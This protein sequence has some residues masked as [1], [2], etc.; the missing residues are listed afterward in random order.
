MPVL[1]DSKQ[2]FEGVTLSQ[3]QF[4]QKLRDG[5]VNVS[6]SQPNPFDVEELWT[7]IL[8]THDALVHIP[9]SSGL[10]ETCS[11]LSHLAH[12]KFDKRVFVADNQRI[13]VT[14]KQSV[15]DAV[16][17]AAEGKS[18]EEIC[19]RL[20]ET[21]AQSSIYIM[22][23]TLK[24][25]KKG[26]RLTPAA[27][28]IGTLLRIK[29]ILQIQGQKLD[30]YAKVRR[31]SDA[32]KTMLKAIGNDLETRF[33]ELRKQGKLAFFVA[34]TD[35]Y[36]AAEQFAQEIR[37]AFPDISF[38]RVLPH[39][40]GRACRCGFNSLLTRGFQAT[41][42]RNFSVAVLKQIQKTPFLCQP[43]SKFG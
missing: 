43:F 23:D 5:K 30:K 18:A 19:S 3:E 8:K 42:K 4:Y 17:M 2:Y 7:E 41:D 10:S 21:R 31:F 38:K 27:A 1:I 29:P 15:R 35:N 32:K 22:V 14:Q 6:T 12:E 34:H 28:A 25:L 39:R 36:A 37:E 26:G 13:S 9:M 16:K 11:T 20:V 24:Y 40:S 33:A